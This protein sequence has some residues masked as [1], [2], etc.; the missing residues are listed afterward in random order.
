MGTGNGDGKKLTP[1]CL[2]TNSPARGRNNFML[3]FSLG[4]PSQKVALHL[5]IMHEECSQSK[6]SQA[7]SQST[8]IVN[9]DDDSNDN[10]ELVSDFTEMLVIDPKENKTVEVEEGWCVVGAKKS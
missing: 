5:M 6:G 8:L 7:V 3:I 1:E 10:S 9:E 4:S 2:M